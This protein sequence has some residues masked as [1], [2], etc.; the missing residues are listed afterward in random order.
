MLGPRSRGS[1]PDSKRNRLGGSVRSK[2]V[3]PSAKA[4]NG[5]GIRNASYRAAS[6][7]ISSAPLRAT[8]GDEAGAD[9]F[10]LPPS[11]RPGHWLTRVDRVLA[12]G[13][14]ERV[15]LGLASSL[16]SNRRSR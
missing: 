7:S 16:D 8:A 13:S 3:W 6:T 15:L 14:F 12:S 10:R 5:L 9:H 1:R 2:S 4:Q 11:C